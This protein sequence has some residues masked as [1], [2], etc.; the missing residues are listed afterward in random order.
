MEI[1][2]EHI[3]LK[4]LS[5]LPG[6]IDS[7]APVILKVNTGLND[8]ERHRVFLIIVLFY[9]VIEGAFYFIVRFE[10]IGTSGK[11]DQTSYE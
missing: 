4:S 5:D 6:P 3:V 7:V 8:F 10:I 11:T 9:F 1:T 2:G